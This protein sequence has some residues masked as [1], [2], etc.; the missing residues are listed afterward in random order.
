MAIRTSN[1]PSYDKIFQIKN[2]GTDVIAKTAVIPAH[3]GLLIVATATN[4]TFTFTNLD[5]T[6]CDMIFVTGNFILPIQIRSYTYT[7]TQTTVSIYGL[8]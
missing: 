5:G 7:G 6:T 2:A 8:Y 4:S 1:Q 3:R